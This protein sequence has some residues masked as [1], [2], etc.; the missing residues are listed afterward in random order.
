[1]GVAQNRSW[2][3]KLVD[4]VFGFCLNTKAPKGGVRGSVKVIGKP[5]VDAGKDMRDVFN[6]PH[7]PG[8]CK[9]GHLA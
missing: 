2:S 8:I 9:D 4:F 7:K 3:P 6:F 5:L 1:M